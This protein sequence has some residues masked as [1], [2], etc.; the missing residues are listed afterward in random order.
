[1]PSAISLRLRGLPLKYLEIHTMVSKETVRGSAQ[2]AVGS[3]KEAA[4]KATGNRK[5]RAEGMTD[6]AAG[7][8]KKAVGKTKD[9]IHRATR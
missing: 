2:K 7:S 8:A 4:G 1:M 3:V 5:L 9:A 6:K